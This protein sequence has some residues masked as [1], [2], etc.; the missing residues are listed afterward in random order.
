MNHM[1]TAVITTGGLGTRILTCTKTNPKAMLPL[2]DRSNDN[3]AEPHLRPLI[4]LVFEHLYDNGIRR[5]CI[6]VGKK[7]KSTIINHLTPDTKFIELLKKRNSPVDK[8]FIKT[9]ERVYKKFNNCEVVWISQATPMGFGHALLSSK[10]FVGNES[11]LLHAG[12]TFIENYDFLPK[13]INLHKK[14]NAFGTLSLQ[15]RN[16]VTGYGIAHF[17][18][19]KNKNRVFLVEE[20]PKKPRSRWI[21]LPIY[22]FKPDVF[23][24]LKNTPKDHNNELQVTD[25]IKTMLDWKRKIIA[26]NFGQRKWFDIG[27]PK[28]YYNAINLSYKNAIR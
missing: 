23:T 12:D 25:A 9:L 7:T 15:Q 8:R 16:D 28:N 11:F 13:L 3:L 26:F 19:I 5:F 6:I 27:T 24:A 21:I 20:K 17:K 4:E 1:K 2:Y 22:V 10:K 18:K 14:T